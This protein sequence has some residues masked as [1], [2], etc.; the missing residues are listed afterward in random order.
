MSFYQLYIDQ[1]REV[2]HENLEL[3]GSKKPFV[4]KHHILPRFQGGSDALS[5][6]I[7]LTPKL[8]LPIGYVIRSFAIRAIDSLF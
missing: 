3:D 2:E 7:Y 4:E 5:N 6:L 1:C 8:L